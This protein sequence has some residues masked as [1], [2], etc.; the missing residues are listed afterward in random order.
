MDSRFYFVNY[1]NTQVNKFKF[2]DNT[3]SAI[4]IFSLGFK[5]KFLQIIAVIIII[6]PAIEYMEGTSPTPIRTHIGFKIASSM[7]IIIDS[8]AEIY[9]IPSLKII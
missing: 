6:D 1:L 5:K 4:L 3:Y 9:F 2:I 7:A 8:V